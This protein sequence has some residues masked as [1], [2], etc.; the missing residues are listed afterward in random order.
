[1]ST[2]NR[3]VV[4]ISR[5]PVPSSRAS[6]TRASRSPSFEASTALED[7]SLATRTS[8]AGSNR[9]TPWGPTTGCNVLPSSRRILEIEQRSSAAASA[10]VRSAALD[11][12]TALEL[13]SLRACSG[14]T[15][16]DEP[17]KHGGIQDGR[18]QD[19]HRDEA[20]SELDSATDDHDL[21]RRHDCGAAASPLPRDADVPTFAAVVSVAAGRCRRTPRSRRRCSV[22][23]PP[24]IRVRQALPAVGMC[25]QREAWRHCHC[26]SYP[27]AISRHSHEPAA[28]WAPWHANWQGARQA[29]RARHPHHPLRGP[30]A[31]PSR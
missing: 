10:R 22:A 31:W 30:R 5:N 25:Q 4:T 17:S 11:D 15:L 23:S 29:S 14:S 19:K 3:R 6:K 7:R 28:A 13:L 2:G 9:C 8:S 18:R 16:I 24:P 1:M 20:G 21:P 26:S 27:L 12:G